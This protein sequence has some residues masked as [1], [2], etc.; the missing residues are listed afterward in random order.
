MLKLL[1]KLKLS[2][3]KSRFEEEEIDGAL[4]MELD[5]RMLENDLN[6]TSSLHRKKIML[7]IQSK[8]IDYHSLF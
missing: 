7:L 6:M 2:Q 4:L 8:S 3:Y 5:D 1:D